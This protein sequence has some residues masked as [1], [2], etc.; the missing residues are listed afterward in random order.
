MNPTSHFNM[1]FVGLQKNRP[2]ESQHLRP[3][4]NVLLIF[5]CMCL[6]VYA[7][8]CRNPQVGRGCL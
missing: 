5:K 6:Q 3:D 8:V 2:H 7:Y 4:L 1:T